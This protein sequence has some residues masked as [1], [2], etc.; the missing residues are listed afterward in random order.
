MLVKLSV[1]VDML[2]FVFLPRVIAIV[3]YR[4]HVVAIN[5]TKFIDV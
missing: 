4:Y 3:I 2:C 5:K 1:T